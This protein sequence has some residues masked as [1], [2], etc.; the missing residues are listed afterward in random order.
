M[1]IKGSSLCQEVHNWPLSYLLV[2]QLLL[3]CV[4]LDLGTVGNSISIFLCV[5]T[6]VEID[7]KGDYDFDF[8]FDL[9]GI[10]MLA[11]VVRI[12]GVALSN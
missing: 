8:D 4:I 2:C 6:Y 5:Q 10:K 11:A 3:L 1:V 12:I 9:C 7:N